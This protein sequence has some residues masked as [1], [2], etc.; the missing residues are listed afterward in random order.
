M[1]KLS[2]LHVISGVQ[3]FT[4]LE[5][6]LSRSRW[7]GGIYIIHC[8][9]GPERP[10]EFRPI[11]RLIGCD[12]EGRLYFGK[13]GDLA[14]RIVQVQRGLS[15]DNRIRNAGVACSSHAGGTSFFKRA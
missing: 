11:N 15:P 14:R 12:L 2:N 7:K 5:R 6:E 8:D 3:L 13:G 10:S 9:A 1:I 4:L